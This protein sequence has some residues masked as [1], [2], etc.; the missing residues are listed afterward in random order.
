MQDK[1]KAQKKYQLKTGYAAQRNY[2]A[3]SDL[4]MIGV[5]VHQPDYNIIQALARRE[6]LSISKFMLKAIK[7]TY[8]EEFASNDK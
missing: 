6:N 2:D 3:K 1:Y 8:K 5:S 7:E 4:K